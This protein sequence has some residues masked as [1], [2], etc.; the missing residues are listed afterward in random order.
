MKS[1]TLK[2]SSK[3][4]MISG[5]KRA[6]VV[7]LS[8]LSCLD[9]M[10]QK[11]DYFWIYSS[12]WS[13]STSV[14]SF[15][16]EAHHYY[17]Y[18]PNRYRYTSTNATMSDTDGN[19]SLSTNGCV[20][21]DRALGLM[22]NGDDINPGEVHNTDCEYGYTAGHQSA[23]I[24]PHPGIRDGFFVF[25]QSI[26]VDSNDSLDRIK[27]DAL[28]YTEVNMAANSGLG[29]VMKKN[30]P[31]ISDTSIY[32][33]NITAAKHEDG[34]S[35]WIVT[36]LAYDSAYYKVL[37]KKD[38][39][40]GPVS[41]RIGKLANKYSEAGGG[42]QFTPDG[43]KYIRWNASDGV[44]IMDFDRSSGELSNFQWI[45]HRVDSVRF[46]GL[47]VSPNSRFLYTSETYVIYQYDLWADDIAASRV[48]IGTYDGFRS[49][50]SCTFW[51]GQLGPDCK[52][53]FNSRGSC[54]WLHVLHKPN[55]KGTA[56]DFR[57]HD[58]SIKSNHFGTMPHFPNYRL[59]TAPTCDST[60]VATTVVIPTS[61][62]PSVKIIPNP[63]SG[64]FQ[65]DANFDYDHVEV[66]NIS[67]QRVLQSSDLKVSIGDQPDG[68]YH[69][70]FWK[71][72]KA[73]ITQRTLKLR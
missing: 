69:L 9:V 35:W 24:I 52:I 53:Y 50:G 22:N 5:I 31:L 34:E 51:A 29:A 18:N 38:T 10:S 49:P 11:H 4:R 28:M 30:V 48:L 19:L 21:L 12:R 40:I 20:I 61:P 27:T 47:S 60:L 16:R 1:F 36:P 56:C 65:I 37:V 17:Q 57:Q 58:F 13:D 68:V 42:A 43:T 66:Y 72:G 2:E 3:N 32:S 55:E 14:I 15:E 73:I 26:I 6:G 67:G 33:A 59:G 54:S 41:Q 39:I 71:D 70:T 63:H 25:H 46:V 62:G 23:I 64:Q 7:L 44:Y 8:L 45:D